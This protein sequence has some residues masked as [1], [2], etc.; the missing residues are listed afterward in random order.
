MITLEHLPAHDTGGAA[1]TWAFGMV[2][3]AAA[4]PEPFTTNA[5]RDLLR[6]WLWNLTRQVFFRIDVGSTTGT[7]STTPATLSAVSYGGQPMLTAGGALT[8][9]FQNLRDRA[10]AALEDELRLIPLPPAG[11]LPPDD[12]SLDVVWA[13]GSGQRRVRAPVES[14][15]AT[16]SGRPRRP[17]HTI[18]G[19]AS[20]YAAPIPQALNISHVFRIPALTPTP[21]DT[22]SIMAAPGL[23]A[24]P[25][26]PTATRP[27]GTGP[28]VWVVDGVPQGGAFKWDYDQPALDA[29]P[30]IAY[31]M[32]ARIRTQ[33]AATER[34][35]FDLRTLYVNKPDPATQHDEEDWRPMLEQRMADALDLGARIL[36]AMR[37]RPEGSPPRTL[38]PPP[39]THANRIAIEQLVLASLRDIAGIG[40]RAAPGGRSLINMALA[41]Y[42]TANDRKPLVESPET[43]AA[44]APVRTRIE[45]RVAVEFGGA[46]GLANWKRFLRETLA[47]LSEAR[48]LSEQAQDAPA[49]PAAHDRTAFERSLAELEHVRMTVLNATNLERVIRAQWQLIAKNDD[50]LLRRLNRLAARAE[51]PI[52]DLRG[53]LAKENLWAF[54]RDFIKL[55][56]PTATDA[57]GRTSIRENFPRLFVTYFRKRFEPDL[58]PTAN[59][60]TPSLALPNYPEPQ[61]PQFPQGMSLDIIDVVCEEIEFFSTR[62]AGQ[63]VAG[64]RPGAQDSSGEVEP[65]D[66]PHAITLQVDSLGELPADDPNMPDADLLD[67]I[68]GV[69]VLMREKPASPADGRGWK[70]LNFASP[71]FRRP[72]P[73]PPVNTTLPLLPPERF[74]TV[75]P[76]RIVYQNDLR[77]SSVTYNNHPISAESPVGDLS[78]SKLQSPERDQLRSPQAAVMQR[79]RTHPLVG[80]VTPSPDVLGGGPTPRR[81]LPGLKF[82]STYEVLPFLITNSGAMPR[83][84]APD[85]PYDPNVEAFDSTATE[86]SAVVR[87]KIREVTYL[88]KVRVGEVRVISASTN[89]NERINFPPVPEGVELRLRD[90]N[91]GLLLPPDTRPSEREREYPI[92][93][94]RPQGDIWTTEEGQRV[95]PV[96]DFFLQTPGTDINT[97]DRWKANDD[98]NRDLR[99]RVWAAYY[100]HSDRKS[101][102]PDDAIT[103]EADNISIDDPAISEYLFAELAEVDGTRI[104][105]TSAEWG[106][107]PAPTPLPDLSDTLRS[108]RRGQIRVSCNVDGG[109]GLTTSMP[110]RETLTA[111]LTKGQ[112]YRLT[113][114]SCVPFE[115]R[116]RFDNIFPRV[117]FG[118]R[119][120]LPDNRQVMRVSPLTFFIETATDELLAG[121]EIQTGVDNRQMLYN[122]LDP[123]FESSQGDDQVRVRML[124]ED[125]RRVKTFRY[126]KRAELSRQVWRWE[127][128]E[129]QQHPRT[130]M[131]EPVNENSADYLNRVERWEEREFGARDELDR[132]VALMETSIERTAAGQPSDRRSFQYMEKLVEQSESNPR[133]PGTGSTDLRALHFRFHVTLF[134]RYAELMTRCASL[135]SARLDGTTGTV[136]SCNGQPVPKPRTIWKPLFVGCRR[137]GPLDP[138]K[139]KF[140]LPLTESFGELSNGSAG[141]LV[142][143]DEQWHDIGGISETLTVEVAPFRDPSLPAS[144][145]Q[146]APIVFEAGPDPLLASVPRE[147]SLPGD[148][149]SFIGVRGPIGHT[150]DRS[151]NAPFFTATSFIVPAP[152]AVRAPRPG[153]PG[154]NPAYHVP[155]SFAKLRFQ[156]NIVRIK[157][158]GTRE[159]VQSPFTQPFWVQYIPEFSLISTPDLKPANLRVRRL[160]EKQ[161]SIVRKENSTGVQLPPPS[162]GQMFE[163]YLILTRRIADVRG[164]RAETFL[165]VF[166]RVPGSDAWSLLEPGN[167]VTKSIPAS[168]APML[169][170]RIIDVQ[171]HP[172]AAAIASES[173]LWK[174]LFSEETTDANR[175]RIVSVSEP[176]EALG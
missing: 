167:G 76:L 20:R 159:L 41:T 152:T 101:A 79:D 111:H 88:R 37:E 109:F 164:E 127:G 89:Q 136:P 116:A 46:S 33:A 155:W 1:P 107:Y 72:Q 103:P 52:L 106:K 97:W 95:P 8:P 174:Q 29:I 23:G 48:V 169:R 64:R 165:A 124:L 172:S 21:T 4:A 91:T 34:L 118:T 92:L 80:Y 50:P 138:P 81:L 66:V 143:F 19:Q 170:A 171:R 59:C 133:A 132:V 42:A 134:S 7:V 160:N 11:M 153:M 40:Y 82:G 163:R 114:W 67:H 99:K 126:I 61:H 83:A 38:P 119:T 105:R 75:V 10:S 32:P 129:T 156:R 27:L 157:A 87:D 146:T 108:I 14:G 12:P 141:A 25:G 145:Q 151:S 161:V 137:E 71:R 144:A 63:L 123:R 131:P 149:V 90:M 18:L 100:Y 175:F 77:H 120:P 2:L 13:P 57:S 102:A 60:A 86:V 58:G 166:A 56:V 140:I 98:A 93:L 49:D 122:A 85:R 53:L 84:L 113:V 69:G 44:E 55:I 68:S 176:I 5:Q 51:F 39:P 168:A 35:Y 154:A 150:F 62:A 15:V 26:F 135:E 24:S 78:D 117:A 147:L 9:F 22:I 96:F 17:W 28:V 162:Q 112:T 94:L 36:E 45:Q 142:V 139:L 70:C 125:R 115:D 128:R 73:N 148:S 104:V 65:T 47:E 74:L 6:P 173:A 158:D 16:E 31:F 43:P 121:D 130:T 110:G 30:V 3:S 54:W